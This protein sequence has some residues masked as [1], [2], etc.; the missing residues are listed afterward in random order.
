MLPAVIEVEPRVAPLPRRRAERMEH[1]FGQRFRCGAAVN[2]AADAAHAAGTLVNVSLSG[3]YIRT[4]LDL[5]LFALIDV[6]AD[7]GDR[8]VELRACVVR[9][10]T[11]GFGVEWCDTPTRSICSTQ[12]PTCQGG[13]SRARK[14]RAE[15]NAS[16]PAA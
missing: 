3:A 9:K 2:V 6:T 14:A 4:A 7:R 15:R 8:R 16:S 5:P 1:R 12:R 11:D 10:D 13:L